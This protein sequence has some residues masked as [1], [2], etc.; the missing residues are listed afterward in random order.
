MQA[1]RYLQCPVLKSQALF[2]LFAVVSDSFSTSLGGLNDFLLPISTT[3]DLYMFLM[4]RHGSRIW[5]CS[6]ALA[7]IVP[8]Q[9]EDAAGS[10]RRLE[11]VAP[12]EV[13]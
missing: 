6:V 9:S 1:V 10:F 7:K 13:L 4:K 3:V 2:C 5:L 8:K 12:V 11:M